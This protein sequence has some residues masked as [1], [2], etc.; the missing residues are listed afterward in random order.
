MKN[1]G[2]AGYSSGEDEAVANGDIF[3]ISHLPSFKKPRVDESLPT[4]A[5]ADA[6]PH[7]LSEVESSL[8]MHQLYFMLILMPGFLAQK[9]SS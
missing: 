5:N 4:P 2:L 8:A 6:A 1:L 9:G 3:G 7:V